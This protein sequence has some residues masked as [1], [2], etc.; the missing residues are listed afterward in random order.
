MLT[1]MENSDTMNIPIIVL[2]IWEGFWLLGIYPRV[3]HIPPP[4]PRNI[5]LKL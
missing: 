3:S 2:K 4:I 5:M 1:I